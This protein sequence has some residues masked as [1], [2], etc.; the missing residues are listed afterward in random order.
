MCFYAKLEEYNQLLCLSEDNMLEMDR[1][2]DRYLL[3]SGNHSQSAEYF[4]DIMVKLLNKAFYDN[5][6]IKNTKNINLFSNKLTLNESSPK[7]FDPE[8]QDQMVIRSFKEIINNYINNN[9][10]VTAT[11]DGNV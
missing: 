11:G 10:I 6:K 1:L 8:N 2:M 5:L 4:S 9:R 7:E 3:E